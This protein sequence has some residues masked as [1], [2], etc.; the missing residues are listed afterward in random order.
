VIESGTERSALEVIVH[1]FATLALVAGGEA[2]GNVRDHEFRAPWSNGS[3][4]L[5]PE[6]P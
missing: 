3:W 5:H 4:R 2:H 1:A 6:P